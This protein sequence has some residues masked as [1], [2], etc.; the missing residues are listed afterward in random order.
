MPYLCRTAR[1]DVIFLLHS[2]CFAPSRMLSWFCKFLS[3]GLCVVNNDGSIVLLCIHLKY[4]EI[5]LL[6]LQLIIHDLV[7]QGHIWTCF[8]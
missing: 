8:N 2:M 5:I 4:F 6:L 1:F 7:S 3:A